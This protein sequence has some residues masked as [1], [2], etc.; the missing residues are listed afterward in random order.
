[1]ALLPINICLYIYAAKIC[2]KQLQIP[3]Y[4]IVCTRGES[5]GVRRT[6]FLI[7]HILEKRVIMQFNMEMKNE[8]KI[9]EGEVIK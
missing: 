2:V 6:A 5:E 1:M 8:K 3:S 7:N 9:I 4:I